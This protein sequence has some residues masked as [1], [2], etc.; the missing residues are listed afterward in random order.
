MK[1][2]IKSIIF[3]LI[4]ISL[5]TCKVANTT[6][7]PLNTNKININEKVKAKTLS[8]IYSRTYFQSRF[9]DLTAV[10]AQSVT[11]IFG[12][13]TGTNSQQLYNGVMEITDSARIRKQRQENNEFEKK[14]GDFNVLTLF[15][16]TFYASKDSIKYFDLALTN[17]NIEHT[18]II[19]RLCTYDKSKL[20][21]TF[22]NDMNN[23]K[24]K[25]ISTFKFQY[26]MADRAGGEQFSMTKKYRLFVRVVGL[27]KDV[28]TNEF[29]WGNKI[30][31]FSD[32][33]YFGKKDAKNATEADM[34]VE[35][36]KI[37]DK[38][39]KVLIN[40]LNGQRYSSEE[41]I[42]DINANDDLF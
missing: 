28:N 24:N 6:W 17:D 42:V 20:D 34:K 30:V 15:T 26:G 5:A 25:Y 18:K 16:N 27:V 23:A 31:I 39:V 19:Q 36:K 9:M 3:S 29:V 38:I 35:F 14:L 37:T 10:I 1:N 41:Q 13:V 11:P 2:F 32:K 33:T 12:G 4:F 40:D 8:S 21:M 7:I 22:T